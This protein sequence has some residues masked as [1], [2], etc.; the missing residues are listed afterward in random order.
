MNLVVIPRETVCSPMHGVWVSNG[1]SGDQKMKRGISHP[2][3]WVCRTQIVTIMMEFYEQQ[4]AKKVWM[5]SSEKEAEAR[6][7]PSSTVVVGLLQLWW[8]S[9]TNKMLKVWMESSENEAKDLLSRLLGL[10]SAGW[11]DLGSKLLT[12]GKDHHNY[13]CM[14]LKGKSK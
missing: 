2:G 6:D 3:C 5:D 8:S 14:D 11:K 1:K 10:L 9:M 7:L 4:N 12:K 13:D